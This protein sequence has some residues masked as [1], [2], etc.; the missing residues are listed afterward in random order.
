MKFDV[1]AG[2]RK[3]LAEL[4]PALAEL[5]RLPQ[6]EEALR[7][8]LQAEADYRNSGERPRYSNQPDLKAIELNGASNRARAACE[9]V[10]SEGRAARSEAGH[11]SALLNA[12]DEVMRIAKQMEILRSERS[13]AAEKAA[14]ATALIDEVRDEIATLESERAA[15]S[16]RGVED[17]LSGRADTSEEIV[18]RIDA[19]LAIKRGRLASAERARANV[20]AELERIPEELAGLDSKSRQA[21]KLRGEIRMEQ[22]AAEHGLDRATA[23]YLAAQA[24]NYEGADAMEWQP[25][26]EIVDEV[27][28]A[29]NAERLGSPLARVLDKNRVDPAETRAAA[30]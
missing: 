3:K 10:K 26:R 21:V 11:I 30:A 29:L 6:Y 9:K 13:A 24:M 16:D 20:A 18:S 8:A 22:W 4:Q 7:A 19:K 27:F 5:E 15:A 2:Y 1:V 17:Q 25:P 14:R 12:G 23:E 28:A